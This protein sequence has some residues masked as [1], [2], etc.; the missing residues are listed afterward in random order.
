M[1]IFIY[2]TNASFASHDVYIHSLEL[3]LIVQYFHLFRLV[4]ASKF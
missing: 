2:S 1:N 3:C 4:P